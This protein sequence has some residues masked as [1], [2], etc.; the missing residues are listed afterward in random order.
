MK[1]NSTQTDIT[2][3][4]WDDLVA[5]EANGYSVL[6]MMQR[7]SAT[8]SRTQ[9]YARVI[10]PFSDKQKARIRAAAVRRAWRRSSSDNPEVVLLGVSVEP[11][12]SDV[13]FDDL[14]GIALPGID[15]PASRDDCLHDRADSKS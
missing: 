6:V 13:R 15:S 5:A 7:T 10:G 14:D 12:W 4:S 1:A 8:S 2:Y 9:S 3:D 11:I